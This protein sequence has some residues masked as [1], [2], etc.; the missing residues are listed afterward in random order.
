M[1]WKGFTFA[2]LPGQLA[3]VPAG[4]L[5]LVEESTRSVESRFGYGSRYLARNNAIP[6]DPVSLPLTSVPGTERL[7]VSPGPGFGAVRDASPDFWGR[8]VIETRL[9]V[10]PNSI[11]ESQYLLAA[12]SHRFGALDF[13]ARQDSPE[14]VGVLPE[15]LRMEYLVEAADRI[16]D[17][18]EIPASL[19]EIFGVSSMGGARP[20]AIVLHKGQ[21]YLAK[22]PAKDDVFNVPVVER[23]VLELA[24]LAGMDVPD[25]DVVPLADGRAVMLI[26][27]FDRDAQPGGFTRHHCV[28]ALTLLGKVEQESLGTPYE[29]I[30]DALGHY[31]VNNFVLADRAE[32]YRRVAFSVLI[33]NDDDHLRNHAFVWNAQGSGWRLSPLYDVV[34]HPQIATER[35]LHLSI[36]PQG[37]LATLDNLFAAHGAFGLLKP[38]AAEIIE[39][40]ASV[41]REW[42]NTFDAC[43]VPPEEVQKVA[44]AF[45]RPADVGLAIVEKFR[46]SR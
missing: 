32:L 35:F 21:Q 36:G 19:S 44:S 27:R 3:A 39:H 18:L 43:Q 1:S 6:V 42:R 46:T 20:K 13:R 4:E 23:A 40:V 25:T 30:S 37:R 26:R 17:G 41:V 24:R 45:R 38:K 34:P 29:A 9:K 12:G 22:F 8:R 33:S 14:S 5:D 15:L 7:Y 10:P 16:Q 28:S 11:P 2:F 31:G